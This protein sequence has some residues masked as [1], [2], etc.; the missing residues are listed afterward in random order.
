MAVTAATLSGGDETPPEVSWGGEA[1]V[2]DGT[3]VLNALAIAQQAA[4]VA[5]TFK[6]CIANNIFDC[7]YASAASAPLS[8]LIGQAAKLF[9]AQQPGD[10]QEADRSW[11]HRCSSTSK[12]AVATL[13]PQRRRPLA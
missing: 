9:A 11:S 5:L 12:T 6:T 1:P 7:P 4:C 2:H 3:A 10:L 13:C 8:I